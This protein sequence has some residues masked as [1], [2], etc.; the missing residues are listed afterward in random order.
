MARWDIGKEITRV[1]LEITRKTMLSVIL[2]SAD[3]PN[4]MAMSQEVQELFPEAQIIV[5]ND[6]HRQGKGWA[7]RHALTE[8]KG[9]LVAFLDGDGDIRPKMI[10]RLL[11][12]IEDYDIVVGV[13]PISGLWSRRIL[14]Y[15]SRIY[16][17]ICF[18]IKVDSQTGVKLFK[19]EAIADFY[20]NGWLFD[21][22]I[23]SVAK[24][25]AYRMIE[26]PIEATVNRRM[27][28][29]SIWRT[30]KESITLWLEL[31]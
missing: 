17:A 8:A 28:I 16:L 7:I 22:E 13:K 31:R 5:C 27:K 23:L 20:S 15:L 6:R 2:P 9:D 29:I 12:F 14:T 25:N 30:F 3:E 24:Q 1:S 10:K 4:A 18:D 11:P 21:L 26:V 19:R